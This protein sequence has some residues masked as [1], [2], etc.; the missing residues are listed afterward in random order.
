VFECRSGAGFSDAA[1]LEFIIHK[2][3]QVTPG[4]AKLKRFAVHLNRSCAVEINEVTKTFVEDGLKLDVMHLRPR[5]PL[6]ALDGL[7][8]PRFPPFFVP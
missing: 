5:S 8:L 1:M 6:S 4:V 3:T 7:P 2:Q